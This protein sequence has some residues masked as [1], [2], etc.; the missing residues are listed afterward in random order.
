MAQQSLLSTIHMKHPY[1]SN[2]MVLG[3]EQMCAQ[4][5]HLHNLQKYPV[6]YVSIEHQEDFLQSSLQISMVHPLE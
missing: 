4:D 5:H 3:M 2:R 1:Y 6:F